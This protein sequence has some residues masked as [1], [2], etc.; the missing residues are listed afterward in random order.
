MHNVLEQGRQ[1]SIYR[2]SPSRS[3]E[4]KKGRGN[5]EPRTYQANRPILTVADVDSGGFLLA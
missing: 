2:G 5:Q 1:H 3:K 4:K